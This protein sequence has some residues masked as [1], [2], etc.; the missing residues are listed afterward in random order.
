MNKEDNLLW[1][2]M[3]RWDRTKTDFLNLFFK[4]IN[5]DSRLRQLNK[6]KQKWQ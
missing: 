3:N 2:E 5:R 6:E 4:L 1:C